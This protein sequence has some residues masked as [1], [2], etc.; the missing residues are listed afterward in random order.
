MVWD[1]VVRTTIW[2]AALA[3]W[4]SLHRPPEGPFVPRWA[5]LAT[6]MGL[7]VA[8]AGLVLYVAG[9][10]TIARAR[11]D[12]RGAA[13]ALLTHGPFRI[14]RNP[15]YL[16]IAILVAGLTL[17]YEAWRIEDLVRTGFLLLTGHLLVVFVEEPAT[18]RRFGASYDAY[19][20]Q[21]PR[22][23]PRLRRLR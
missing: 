19:R 16:G 3:L 10:I 20:G 13:T 7:L 18:A 8:V 6:V 21:V 4:L 22:W 2:A 9:A 11:R 17:L 5:G 14:V 12:T 23:V 15:I 1:F